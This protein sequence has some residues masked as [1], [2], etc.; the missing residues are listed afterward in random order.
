MND[1]IE[2]PLHLRPLFDSKF[3]DFI[4]IGPFVVDFRDF[5]KE[6]RNEKI[7]A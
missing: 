6:I 2:V 7:S 5:L 3:Y 4:H 1:V